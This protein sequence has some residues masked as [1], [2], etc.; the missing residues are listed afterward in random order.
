[1]VDLKVTLCDGDFHEIDS[2]LLAFK[3]AGCDAF[4]KGARRAHPIL[5]EPVMQVE[6][7]APKEYMG[8]IIKDL[9]ARKGEI[10]RGEELHKMAIIQAFVPLASLFNYTTTLRSLTQGRGTSSIFPDRYKK[11]SSEEAQKIIK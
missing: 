4:N 9:T 3:L 1:M 10:R 7:R 6:V 5:L 8:K 2:S 11:V